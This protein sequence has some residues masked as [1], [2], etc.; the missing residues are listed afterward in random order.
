MIYSDW[1]PPKVVEEAKQKEKQRFETAVAAF[2]QA[3]A[4]A[5][6]E[7]ARGNP[8]AYAAVLGQLMDDIKT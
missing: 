5:E 3:A 4:V 8:N 2:K 6:A 1:L 7:A